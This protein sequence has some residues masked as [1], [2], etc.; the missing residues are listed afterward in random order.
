MS[1]NFGC[2]SHSCYLQKPEGMG[3]NGPCGCFR[4]VDILQRRL[5]LNY[6]NHLREHIVDLTKIVN[7]FDSSKLETLP[8]DQLWD[9]IE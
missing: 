9:G 8:I 6:I 2:G 5:I 7:A 1:K 4:S 3:T